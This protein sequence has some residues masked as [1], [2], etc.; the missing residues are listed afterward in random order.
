MNSPQGYIA[1]HNA[2]WLAAARRRLGGAGRGPRGGTA[3]VVYSPVLKSGKMEVLTTLLKSGIQGQHVSRGTYV[4][5]VLHSF[6]FHMVVNQSV[7][8]SSEST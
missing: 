6:L 5:I 1:C 8:V 7:V 3:L 4:C 2:R